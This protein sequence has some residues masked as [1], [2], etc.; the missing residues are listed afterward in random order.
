MELFVIRHARAE[1]PDAERWPDD[2]LRPL[3]RDGARDFERLARRMRRWKPDVD[4]VL[5]S[6]WTR[7]WDTA[8]IL[9]AHAG[10][11]K[12]ARTKLLE[13]DEP[14]AVAGVVA[15]VREQ[16]VDAR[17]ALVGHEPVLGLLVSGLC[18]GGEAR[19]AMRKGAV[20]WLRG[21]PGSMSLEGLLVPGMLRRD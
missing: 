12:P 11:P 14:S 9:R 18:S 7:A 10:W 17:I 4:L 20:A 19:V 3:T 5:A 1:E 2:A 13:S 8:R 16:P 6:G 15:L 21:E